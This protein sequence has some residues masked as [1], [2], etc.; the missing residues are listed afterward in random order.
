MKERDQEHHRFRERAGNRERE[1]KRE[2]ERAEQIWAQ[3]IDMETA[4]AE[5]GKQNVDDSA[6]QRAM[7]LDCRNRK[8]ECGRLSMAESNADLE[9]TMETAKA[10][11]EKTECG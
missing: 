6:R 10:E 4:R 7:H 2:R 3:R 1:T 5:T 8:A 9:V 11:T